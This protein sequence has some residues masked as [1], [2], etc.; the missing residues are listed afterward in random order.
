MKAKYT[1]NK[2]ETY[3]YLRSDYDTR[4]KITKSTRY[5]STGGKANYVKTYYSTGKVKK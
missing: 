3:K 5:Y 2:S 1:Y 4:G